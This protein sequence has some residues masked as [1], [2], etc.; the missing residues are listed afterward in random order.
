M[1]KRVIAL[2]AVLLV[3]TVASAGIITISVTN[4]KN[5]TYNERA[6]KRY[7]HSFAG[8]KLKNK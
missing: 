1:R 7:F 2:F 5:S 8:R 6:T 4:D 3:S